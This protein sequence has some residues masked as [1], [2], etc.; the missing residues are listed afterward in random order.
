MAYS[1]LQNVNIRNREPLPVLEF[2]KRYGKRLQMAIHTGE[3]SIDFCITEVG[4]HRPGL[5]LA[6]YTDVYSSEQIQIIGHTEWNYLESIGP[7]RRRAAFQKFMNFKAPMWVVTHGQKPHKELCEMCE[8]LHIPLFSTPLYTFDFFFKTKEILEY[9][10]APYAKLHASL[11]D[12]YGIGM[13]YVGDSNVGKSECVLDLV[14]RGHRL[15]ADDVVQLVHIGNTLIGQ[16]DPLVGHCMEIRGIGVID[17]RSMF[18]I[19]AVRKRK[20]VEVVVELRLWEHG[21]SG[22]DRT[23]LAGEKE[24]IMGV[25][26]P[27]I[28]I[29]VSPGKNLTVIS[30]VIAM[31]TLMKSAGEDSAKNFNERLIEKIR[32][33]AERKNSVLDSLEEMDLTPY[34]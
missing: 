23:G 24:N 15:V 8:A 28:T 7:E 5:A 27:L 25:E 6:G 29:P 22:C 19:H 26:L 9:W 2:F 32:Q 11:V 10:F 20:K 16:A 12:V 3:S 21:S 30:E 33:K 1:P 18:G 17:V 14:E 31:N 4:L 34:E 13:L